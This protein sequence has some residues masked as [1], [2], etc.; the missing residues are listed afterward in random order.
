MTNRDRH[1][2]DARD[3]GDRLVAG[4]VSKDP[5]AAAF[6]P[7]RIPMIVDDPSQH[8]NPIKASILNLIRLPSIARRL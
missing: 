5:F 6:K 1:Q 3:A 7:T 4:H 2:T 8:D